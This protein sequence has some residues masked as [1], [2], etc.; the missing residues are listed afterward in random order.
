MLADGPDSRSRATAMRDFLR[1][2]DRQTIKP[3]ARPKNPPPPSVALT[4]SL[5]D[6]PAVVRVGGWALT[7]DTFSG[8]LVAVHDDGSRQVIATRG[9]S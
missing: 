2:L 5:S 4:A 3:P 6:E 8:D 7:E 1:Q 9:E